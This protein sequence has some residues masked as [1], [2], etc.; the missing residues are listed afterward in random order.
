MATVSPQR[1][2]EVFVEVADTLVDDFDVIE[3]LQMIT[4]RTA[5]LIGAPAVGL[6][7]AD[8]HGGL[9]FMAASDEAT[10]LLELFQVQNREGPCLDAFTTQAPVM[11]ADLRTAEDRWP[12]F[13]P[14]ATAAGFQSVH[15]LPLRLRAQVIGALNLF[16]IQPGELEPGDVRVVQALAD[17]ATIGLLQERAIRRGEVLTEQLQ[18]ALTSRVVVEQAKGA[19]ARVHAI[20]VD[21]AFE[22]LRRYARNHN[23]KLIDVARA[24]VT[25]PGSVP[26][27]TRP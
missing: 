21:R 10:R 23:L 5:E 24:V 11:N 6:L 3:F 27:L 7:L 1:L 2:A 17:V 12:V 4:A 20:D 18:H 8:V 14:Q 26:G 15:A 16:G 13:A 9:Q 19:L 25:N 22:V